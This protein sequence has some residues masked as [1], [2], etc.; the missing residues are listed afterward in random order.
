LALNAKGSVDI[1]MVHGDHHTMMSEPSVQV[2]AEK[3]K[4]CLEQSLMI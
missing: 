2:L 4:V 1:L 3:L